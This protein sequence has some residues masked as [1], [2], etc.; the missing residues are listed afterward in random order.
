MNVQLCEQ[1][2]NNNNETSTFSQF[3]SSTNKQVKEMN[4]KLDSPN[5]E[6]GDVQVDGT[7]RK[8]NNDV[9]STCVFDPVPIS[10]WNKGK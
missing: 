8:P 3:S 10:V 9:P 1:V 2:K 5:L 6:Q 7:E 4:G